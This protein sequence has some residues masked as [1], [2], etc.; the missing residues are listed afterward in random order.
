MRRLQL[1]RTDSDVALN[2][3][4]HGEIKFP[5]AGL[6]ATSACR[7][8]RGV[9]AELR[10]HPAGEIAA[11]VPT[12]MEI[13]L[14]VRGNREARVSRK[15]AGQRQETVVRDGTIWLCPVGVGEEDVYISGQL[16]EIL[17]VYL[18]SDR[19]TELAYLYGDNRIRADA[20]QYLAGVQDNLIRQL[21]LSMLAE[22]RNESSG[23]RLLVE[24]AA[25]A[26]TAQLAHS[27]SC[28]FVARSQPRNSAHN[29]GERINRAVCFIR[30]NLDGDLSVADLADVACLSPFHFAR[31]FKDIMG[32]TPHSYVS[33]QRLEAAKRRILEGRDSLAGIALDAGFSSQSAFTRRFRAVTGLTP[34][35][36][37]RQFS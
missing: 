36:F 33:E 37:R 20:V 12:Q 16:P 3:Y 25:L 29:C 24:S 15:G 19:F 8:W 32:K 7:G 5:N 11:P 30:D 17:H 22:L 34:G 6:L 26:L 21:A 27:H 28:D 14:A 35:A 1:T 2:L 18:P 10:S 4:A 9:A 31:M 13:T 23:G